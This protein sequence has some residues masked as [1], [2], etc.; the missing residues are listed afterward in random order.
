MISTGLGTQ[1]IGSTIRPA[2]YCGCIGFKSTV[3]ALN[4]GGSYDGLSQS[5]T[6]VLA[7]TLEDAWQVA[8][9]IAQRAGGDPGYPG[10]YGPA[11]VPPA[12]KPKRIAFIE[13]AGWAAA[14]A[15]AKAAMEDALKRLK[16]SRHRGAHARQST[17]RL[18]PPKL[19]SR[20]R[21]R[22]RCASTAGKAAGRSTPIATATRASSAGSCSSAS[23]KPRP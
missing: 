17:T 14:S 12:Q 18:R 11:S 3:G 21:D 16:R 1:V 6:G 23:P 13:T 10:L 20:K 4:R 15:G 5:S 7:S 22:C 8:Y 9:E 2:S 19:P